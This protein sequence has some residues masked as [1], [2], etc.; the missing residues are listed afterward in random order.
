MK[1][2]LLFLV[3]LLLTGPVAFAQQRITLNQ[4]LVKIQLFTEPSFPT[5]NT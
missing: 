5:P 1:K 4:A 2:P 3:C